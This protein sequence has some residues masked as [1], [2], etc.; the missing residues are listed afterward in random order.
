MKAIQPSNILA[1]QI[2]MRLL[3]ELGEAVP[4]WVEALANSKPGSAAAATELQP[5]FDQPKADSPAQFEP[6]PERVTARTNLAS[7]KRVEEAPQV[8]AVR[9]HFPYS[10]WSSGSTKPPRMVVSRSSRHVFVQ[11]VDDAHGIT[12]V[13]ASTFEPELRAFKGTKTAKA[14]RVGEL[15]AER[16]KA[17]GI[18][19][20]VFDR[21]G[22][23]FH[24]R[25]AAIAEGARDRGLDTSPDPRSGARRVR[26]P[27]VRSRPVLQARREVARHVQPPGL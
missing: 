10:R 3:S 5:P 19:A 11:I 23:K 25:V 22:R 13:H 16:A 17:L 4:D 26:Q 7:T 20:V 24:G 1:A 2:Q 8:R 9:T 6:A 12:L 27:G 18:E 15:V 21:G 14:K